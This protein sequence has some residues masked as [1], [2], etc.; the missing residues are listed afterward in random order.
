MLTKQEYMDAEK[1]ARTYQ[2]EGSILDMY[3]FYKKSN[4]K[5]R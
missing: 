2:N 3:F 1:G 4:C 5:I